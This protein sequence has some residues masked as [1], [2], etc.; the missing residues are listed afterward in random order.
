MC[1]ARCPGCEFVRTQGAQ[2]RVSPFAFAAFVGSAV[3]E[4][5]SV[6]KEPNY[7]CEN[8]FE[9]AARDEAT[10]EFRTPDQLHKQQ[11][12]LAELL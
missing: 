4:F 9:T 11:S 7:T 10:R 5:M 3:P 12:D 2:R 8:P 6:L 1:G